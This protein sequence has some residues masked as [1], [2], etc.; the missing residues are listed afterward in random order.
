MRR[1]TASG[2]RAIRYIDAAIGRQPCG[3]GEQAGGAHRRALAGEARD[4][5]EARGLDGL[6][7]GHRRQDSGEPPRQHRRPRPG[8]PQEKDVVSAIRPSN[9]R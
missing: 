9:E 5:V 7:E 1:L 6:G 4:A 8:R 2:S 3:R